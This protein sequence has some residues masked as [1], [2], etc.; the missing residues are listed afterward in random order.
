MANGK[1]GRGEK[2]AKASL[3][4]SRN[5]VSITGDYEDDKQKFNAMVQDLAITFDSN[6]NVLDNG[7]KDDVTL[8]KSK[9]ES[10]V[11]LLGVVFN[12][13][14]NITSESYTTHTH[15]YQDGTINDTAD[16]T[17]IQTDTARNTNGVN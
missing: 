5:K 7:I 13:S 2:L 1:N 14:G 12:S 4:V 9:M 16:G 11:A 10:L 3:A 17:G 8:L 15:S 6:N